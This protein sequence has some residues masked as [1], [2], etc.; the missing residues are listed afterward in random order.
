MAGALRAD[1]VNGAPTWNF[2]LAD[3]RR[4]PT[5]SDWPPPFIEEMP[6]IAK[7]WNRREELLGRHRSD[8][9]SVDCRCPHPIRSWMLAKVEERG[10]GFMLGFFLFPD[11]HPREQADAVAQL[12]VTTDE[13]GTGTIEEAWIDALAVDE[14]SPQNQRAI[15]EASQ[16]MDRGASPS[17]TEAPRSS[18]TENQDDGDQPGKSKKGL[19]V[20]GCVGCLV[21]ILCAGAAGLLVAWRGGGLASLLG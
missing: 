4:V 13:R 8:L 17:A 18:S 2:T 20:G 14:L 10:S 15:R 9:F 3:T 16:S 12:L 1:P 11:E 5:L 7:V 19:V 21:L 6:A